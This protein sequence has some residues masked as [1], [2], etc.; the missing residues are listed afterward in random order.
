MSMVIGLT[1]RVGVGKSFV[2]SLLVKTFDILHLD[3]DIIGHEIL[4]DP[5]VQ[6]AVLDRF[7]VAD[8][9]SLGA[10]VF[11]DK[12]ALQDLNA[13][14]HPR[15][16]AFVLDQLKL[17]AKPVVISGALLDEIWLMSVCD[18]IWVV[19]AP[20]DVIR[21]RIGEKFDKIISVQRSRDAYLDE[22]DVVF[23]NVPDE[24]V[25]VQVVSAFDYFVLRS[26]ND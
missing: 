26:K 11:S 15:M 7:G 3:L 4:L 13:M 24:D 8:R 21:E 10:I 19:D 6:A 22:A 18:Q 20:D 14:M 9:A 1:G 5:V 12:K 23:H 25:E 17:A 2:A 16:K